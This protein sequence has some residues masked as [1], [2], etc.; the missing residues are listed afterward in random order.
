MTITRLQLR[1]VRQ[2]AAGC[3]EYCLL[4]ENIETLT[5]HVDHIVPV[6]HG[7]DDSSRNLCLACPDCNR[8]KGPN[9]AALDPLTGEP[10][11]LYNPREQAWDEHFELKVDMTITGLT[12]EG[13]AATEVLRMNLHRR[14][15]ERY[16]AWM[17]GE[18]PGEI[19]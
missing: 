15:V 19:S 8:A 16:E 14:V 6:A 18:Y 2:R 9:V 1:E 3:C 10:T 7:G 4:V 13:R 12:P 11:R 17:R 5:F